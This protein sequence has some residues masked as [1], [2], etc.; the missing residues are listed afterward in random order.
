MESPNP[1]PRK[2]S[3]EAKELDTEV[4]TL[5]EDLTASGRRLTGNLHRGLIPMRA[6]LTVPIRPGSWLGLTILGLN[7]GLF[8]LAL[9]DARIVLALAFMGALGGFIGLAWSA[10]T[11]GCWAVAPACA[12]AVI[13]ATIATV[14]VLISQRMFRQ[15]IGY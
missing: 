1:P 10:L 3:Y 7:L 11:I 2:P 15:A 14:V 6:R 9:R 4:P 5:L 13:L 8:L 12:G